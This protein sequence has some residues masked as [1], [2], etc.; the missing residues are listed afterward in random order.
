MNRVNPEI[1][2][3]W[4]AVLQE[5]FDADYFQRLKAFLIEEKRTHTVYPPGSRIFAAFDR[6]PLPQVRAVII[7]QDPYHGPGQA[8]GLCF[9]VPDG[10]RP[11]PSLKNIFKEIRSDLG[12]EPRESGNLERWAAQGVLLINATLTVRAHS[13]GSHQKRGWERFTDAAMRR[14]SEQRDGLVF[15]LWGAYAQRKAELI[16]PVRH[17]ILQAPHPS[18]LSADRGFFGCRH[19]SQ[20]N[21]YLRAQGVPEI[22]WR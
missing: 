21:A 10:V 13:A 6:T 8:H 3:S 1:E 15:L 9:S 19:F 14:L 16:D 18:P 12:I 11:P 2:P 17:H 5:E 20:T 22:D 4:K 7:G